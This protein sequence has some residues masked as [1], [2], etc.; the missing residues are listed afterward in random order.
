MS[1]KLLWSLKKR[2]YRLDPTP[3]VARRRGALW[4]LDPSDWLDLQLLIGRPFEPRQMD[5]MVRLCR[6]AGVRRFFDV[7]ANI[8]LYSVLMP[9]LVAGIARVDAFEP[10]AATRWRLVAN[11]G[12]N[13][14]EGLVAVHDIALSDAGGEAE[15][16][17]D[18]S[19]SGVST[20]SPS[21]RER[22][23]REF[24]RAERVARAR[25]DALFPGLEGPLAFKID[26]E[27]HEPAVL[28]GMRATLAGTPS[29]V[30][31]EARPRNRDR[32]E[33]L[34]DGLGYAAVER[35]DDDLFFRGP[36]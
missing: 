11:L 31:V 17:I 36:R 19:S 22:D 5:C 34:F 14:L 26:V 20:L 35:I 27:G 30:Q 28:E 16:A 15:I 2:A 13:G 29:I 7:G 18:P 3:R 32:V 1:F 8:G 4:L 24:T 6:D 25:F 9:R 21:A 10:V 23:H 12:L 33:A